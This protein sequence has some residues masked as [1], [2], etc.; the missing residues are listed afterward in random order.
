MSFKTTVYTFQL[1]YNRV[2]HIYELFSIGTTLTNYTD[3][4]WIKMAASVLKQGNE[5]NA[6]LNNIGKTLSAANG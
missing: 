6:S 3:L 4:R 1:Y 5:N 2:D